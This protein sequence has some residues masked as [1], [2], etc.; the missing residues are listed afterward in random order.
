MRF[1]Q[2]YSRYHGFMLG[3]FFELS[4]DPRLER[5]RAGMHARIDDFLRDIESPFGM[6]PSSAMDSRTR[7]RLRRRLDG[8]FHRHPS[9]TW[10]FFNLGLSTGQLVRNPRDTRGYDIFSW[11]EDNMND[12]F[13]IAPTF[14]NEVNA[15]GEEA[16]L[17]DML[18]PALK[19][20]HSCLAPVGFEKKSCFVAMPFKRSFHRSYR[21]A[22]S[23]ALR[24]HGLRPI[25]AW[26]SLRSEEYQDLLFSLVRRCGHL[27]ADVSDGNANV[28]MELGYAMGRAHRTLPIAASGAEGVS[29][30]RPRDLIRYDEHDLDAARSSLGNAVGRWVAR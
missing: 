23:P 16:R 5:D 21:E 2:L 11:I 12:N 15:L 17:A 3:L 4:G 19:M 1:T 9:S 26:G 10:P 22:L 13:R 27:I 28:L 6:P 29:N 14:L 30:V 25:R 18:S 20:L 24:A 7:Y 8:F